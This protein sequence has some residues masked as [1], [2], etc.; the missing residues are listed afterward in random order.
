MNQLGLFDP[1]PNCPHMIMLHDMSL[2]GWCEEVEHDE[3]CGCYFGKKFDLANLHKMKLGQGLARG[4]DM[5]TA[6]RAGERKRESGTGKTDAVA[7]LLVLRT[8]NDYTDIEVSNI[9]GWPDPAKWRR[10]RVELCRMGLVRFAGI[11]RDG[12]AVWKA[13]VKK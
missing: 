1:C 10:R 2:R 6:I 8:G 3:F 13:R 9:L 5:P 4:T 12:S 7:G 11:K